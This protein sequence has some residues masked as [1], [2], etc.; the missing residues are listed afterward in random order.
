[1]TIPSPA[2]LEKFDELGTALRSEL[3]E[4]EREIHAALVAFLAPAHMFLLGDPGIAKSFLFDRLLARITG[5]KKFSLL[6]TRYTTPD[7]V[8]GPRDV[9]AMKESRVARLTD[10]YLPDADAAFEDEIWKASSSILNTHLKILNE[11]TFRNDGKIWKVPLKVLVCASNELPE[12]GMETAAIAD[13]IPLWL[14]VKDIQDPDNF[15][16]MLELEIDDEPEPI[17]TWTDILAAQAEVAQVRIERKVL[18][19]MGDLRREL[20]EVNIHLTPRR[21]R[22]AKDIM[23]AEA[24]LDGTDAVE[25][26]HMSILVHSAWRKPEEQA[27]AERVILEVANPLEKR[28]TELLR[29]IEALGKQIE[30]AIKDKAKGHSRGM[31]IH[32]DLDRAAGDLQKLYAEAGGGRRTREMLDHAKER[33]HTVTVRMIVDLFNLPLEAVDTALNLGSSQ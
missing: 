33:L 10:G 6:M 7:E 30:V 19:A 3:V 26:E 31:D 32:T 8:Y 13:R 23:R 15:V 12:G 29:G 22:K 24:W 17:L 1:M 21:W 18:V 28:T 9:V 5:A 20:A 25:V 11:G 16:K 2:L 27:E 4:R 14:E